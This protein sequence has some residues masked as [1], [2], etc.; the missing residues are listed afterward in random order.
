MTI[1]I[2]ALRLGMA[3]YTEAQQKTAADIAAAAAAWI[4]SSRTVRRTVSGVLP[5][6]LQVMRWCLPAAPQSRRSNTLAARAAS[7]APPPRQRPSV[8]RP[9]SRP[10]TRAD[11]RPYACCYDAR[12][13]PRSSLLPSDTSFVRGGDS[14]LSV[15]VPP[16]DTA[17]LCR[18][19]GVD[20][21]VDAP[22]GH[23]ARG[24]SRRV[25]VDLKR[26]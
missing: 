2:P 14:R 9:G 15:A 5:A 26:E 19:S 10:R 4:C 11:R 25:E 24:V 21:S 13:L 17:K 1:E 18:R 20:L 8:P 23:R 22:S 7:P 16:G 3:G 12:A 6:G